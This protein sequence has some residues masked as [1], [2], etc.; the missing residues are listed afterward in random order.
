M[1]A[2]SRIEWTQRTWN[3]VTGCSKVSIGCKN[4]YAERLA[5]RLQAMG[6]PRY[7]NGF[8]VTLHPDLL[9]VPLRWKTPSLIFVNSM[10]DLFHEEIPF[11][12]I[13]Q[14]FQTMEAA[15]WHVFQILTKRSVRLRELA[16]RLPWPPNVWIG[17]TVESY[18][19]YDRI[20][21]LQT[22]PA[23]IR[24]LSCEPL[25]SPME[26]LPLEGIHWVI[27]GG[28]SGPGARPMRLEWVLSIKEQ[29]EHTG[30]PFF[31][32]Q[33]GGTQKWRNGRRLLGREYNEMPQYADNKEQIGGT[34]GLRRRTG[35]SSAGGTAE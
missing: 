4:C 21:D 2:I 29:C 23:Q 18:H 32:K 28:E 12:F 25:L 17:V 34:E 15:S 35:G 33:W 1:A 30:I 13:R 3:P 9:S 26:N 5:R 27:V 10:S 24:F 20:A 19:Y 22:V 7:R 6:N 11:S 16:P 14:V 31:F 8:R